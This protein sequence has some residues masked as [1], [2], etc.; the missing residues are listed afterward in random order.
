M[1][2][3]VFCV[4]CLDWERDGG[5]MRWSILSYSYHI[6]HHTIIVIYY[7]YI[8]IIIIII[9]TVI[10]YSGHPGQVQGEDDCCRLW[11]LSSNTT[12]K[13]SDLQVRSSQL[14]SAALDWADTAQGLVRG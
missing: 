2:F 12:C 14:Q 8:I 3:D 13:S 7:I 10:L 1:Y 9:L 6:S 11:P 5:C 4:D